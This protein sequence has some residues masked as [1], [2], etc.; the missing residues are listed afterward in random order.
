M[1]AQGTRQTVVTGLLAGLLLVCACWSASAS[2]PV[3]AQ[4][5]AQC[6]PE[7]GQCISVAL[8]PAWEA[9]GGL[10][11][12]GYP[13]TP[14]RPE[15]NRDTGRV[16]LT[17]WFERNRLEL[18]P[19]GTLFGRLG[20]DRLRQQGIDWQTLPKG[21]PV[22]G[23]DFFPETGH[24]LCDQEPSR[25]FKTYWT[26]R[27]GLTF[28]G[29]PLTEPRLETNASGDTVLT[30]WFERARFEWHPDNPDEFKVLLGLLG[31]EVGPPPLAIPGGQTATVQR[32]IDG[33]TIEVTIG[34]TTA[35]VRL[36]GVDT[37]ET[38]APGRPVE[39]YGPEA[40]AFTRA[41]LTGKQVV[42][43]KDVSE[44]DRFG[45]LLRY[46]WLDGALVNERLVTEGYAQVATFPPD[47]RYAELFL[48]SQQNAR[49]AGRG[50][51]GAGCA[52]PVGPVPTATPLPAPTATAPVVQGVQVTAWVSTPSPPQRSSVTVYGQLTVDGRGVA[53]V[54]MTTTWHY[55]TTT[56]SCEGVTGADGVASCTQSIGSATIG[57]PVVVDVVF[58]YQG[59]TYSAQ[60]RFTPR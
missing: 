38:V 17:Q 56:S 36:I 30:Q 24:A 40:S 2:T 19:T 7:T 57:Y 50:L 21:Y 49:A 31:R 6:F 35:T 58:T 48:T 60:T 33:D 34:V 39:C 26:T 4:A 59:R 29:F 42:L 41:L 54:P 47:V 43:E 45:R 18:H 23:C 12:I 37:P 8:L 55:R 46:V 13:I 27:G 25:G 11:A 44:T 32:V 14:A 3:R 9:S 20:D 5:D 28:F 1:M 53:G 51:W 22:E 52:G 10:A 15:V 16:V